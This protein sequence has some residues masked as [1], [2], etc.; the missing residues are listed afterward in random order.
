LL[1]FVACLP[2]SKAADVLGY[3]LLRCGTSIGANYRESGRAESHAD[4]VHKLGIVEREASETQYWLELCRDM[5]LGDPKPVATLLDE[6]SQLL[7]IFTAMCK[8]AKSR[9]CAK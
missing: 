5:P 6:S 7:A 8:T 9:H 4:F 1:R 3:Q 2:K